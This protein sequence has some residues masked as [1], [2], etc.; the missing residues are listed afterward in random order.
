VRTIDRT[1]GAYAVVLDN[2]PYRITGAG[3]ST[4]APERDQGKP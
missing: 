3:V 1:S 4:C 2:I